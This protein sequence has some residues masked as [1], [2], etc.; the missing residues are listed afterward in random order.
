VPINELPLGALGKFQEGHSHK[1]IASQL[2]ADSVGSAPEIII[3]CLMVVLVI[4]GW[5]FNWMMDR[6]QGSL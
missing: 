4:S 6:P 3:G 1:T 5:V 2:G